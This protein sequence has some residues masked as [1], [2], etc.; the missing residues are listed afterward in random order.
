VIP[1]AMV[2]RDKFPTAREMAFPHRNHPVEAF[3]FDRSDEQGLPTHR[4]SIVLLNV[5]R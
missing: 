4:R 1:F 5:P 3:F 2:V